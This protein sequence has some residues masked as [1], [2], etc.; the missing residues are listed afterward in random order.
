MLILFFIDL[1]NFEINLTLKKICIF[2]LERVLI[3]Q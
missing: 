2:L 3:N 1:V